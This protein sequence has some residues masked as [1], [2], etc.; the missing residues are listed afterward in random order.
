MLD[1]P[2]LLNLLGLVVAMASCLTMLRPIGSGSP[3]QI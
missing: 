2:T 3:Y 1:L